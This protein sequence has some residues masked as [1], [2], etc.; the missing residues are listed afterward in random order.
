V[1]EASD[2]E[3]SHGR[4]HSLGLWFGEIQSMDVFWNDLQMYRCTD[5]QIYSFTGYGSTILT[6]PHH[7]PRESRVAGR[8]VVQCRSNRDTVITVCAQ[9][10]GLYHSILSPDQGTHLRGLYQQKIYSSCSYLFPRECLWNEAR[11]I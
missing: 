1:L 6:I 2:D 4:L 11:G 5:V 3:D 8:S 10:F 9:D 7:D